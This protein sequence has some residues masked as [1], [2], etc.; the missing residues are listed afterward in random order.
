MSDRSGSGS[1]KELSV[2]WVPMQKELEKS[3]S[4][5]FVQLLESANPRIKKE[6]ITPL[7]AQYFFESLMEMLLK[8]YI[9]GFYHDGQG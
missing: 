6:V 3:Y 9:D 2:K 5:Q 1:E 8:G 7:L 4:K